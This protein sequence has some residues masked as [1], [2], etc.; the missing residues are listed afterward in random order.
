MGKNNREE[1][2]AEGTQAGSASSDP[3][4]LFELLYT[5]TRQARLFIQ[6]FSA[7]CPTVF[8]G[9]IET[10]LECKQ[11]VNAHLHCA[12]RSREIVHGDGS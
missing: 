9:F 7:R 12:W 6:A 10:S 4:A 3:M 1:S 8:D 11:P 2:V 5:N